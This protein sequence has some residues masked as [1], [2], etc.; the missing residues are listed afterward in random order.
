MS[1]S[2]LLT[3]FGAFILYFGVML[4]GL[5]ILFNTSLDAILTL[6]AQGLMQL[7]KYILGE[8]NLTNINLKDKKGPAI[9]GMTNNSPAAS[10]NKNQKQ[11]EEKREP[12]EAKLVSNVPG[13]TKVWKYPPMSL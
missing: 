8:K 10:E 6:I 7:K 12:I 11:Q 2:G 4:V 3:G 1:V 9:G 5:I 13:E